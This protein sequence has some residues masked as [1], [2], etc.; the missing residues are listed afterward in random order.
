MELIMTNKA[1]TDAERAEFMLEHMNNDKENGLDR[2]YSECAYALIRI[3]QLKAEYNE[4]LK[5]ITLTKRRY[6]YEANLIKRCLKKFNVKDI[7]RSK[8]KAYPYYK[9]YFNKHFKV[10]PD[11][12]MKDLPKEIIISYIE[13]VACDDIVNMEIYKYVVE[14]IKSVTNG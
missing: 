14:R 6:W 11:L 2:K 9:K 3:S 1:P 13:Q 8:T 7:Y 12:F 5:D 10:S 4:N